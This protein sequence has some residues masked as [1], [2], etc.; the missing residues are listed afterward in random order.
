[1]AGEASSDDNSSSDHQRLRM[2]DRKIQEVLRYEEDRAKDLAYAIATGGEIYKRLKAP[3]RLHDPANIG[4][5]WRI[6]ISAEGIME[7]FWDVVAFSPELGS[8]DVNDSRTAASSSKMN[9][10]LE[11]IGK[12]RVSSF[13]RS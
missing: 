12:V 4:D 6:D 8:V 11:D 5:N 3:T 9:Y 1:M 13:S 2:L 7:R 10:I